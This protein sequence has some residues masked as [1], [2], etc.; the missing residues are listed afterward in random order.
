MDTSSSLDSHLTLADISYSASALAILDAI[1]KRW[2]WA[3]HLFA[4]VVYDRLKLM[5]KAGYLDFVVQV[6]RRCV[7]QEGF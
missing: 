4:D 2:P 1:R 3:T 7:E 6:V 5:D